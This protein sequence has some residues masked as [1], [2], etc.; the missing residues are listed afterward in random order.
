MRLD[1]SLFG[2]LTCLLGL[3][4]A[5]YPTRPPAQ[6]E[7]TDDDDTATVTT[8]SASSNSIVSLASAL[9][10][11]AVFPEDS[12]NRTLQFVK[13]DGISELTVTAVNLV[14]FRGDEVI[15]RAEFTTATTP[16][17]NASLDKRDDDLDDRSLL[18]PLPLATGNDSVILAFTTQKDI[19]E[20]HINEALYLEFQWENSTSSGSSFSPVLAIYSTYDGD[21]GALQALQETGKMDGEPAK[22][23]S[24]TGSADDS[25]PTTAPSTGA[26]TSTPTSEASGNQQGVEDSSSSSSSSG[27]G[28]L[29][30]G[31]IAGIAVGCTLAGLALLGGVLPWFFCFRRR[32]RGRNHRNKAGFA[33]DSGS[34]A[35]MFGKEITSESTTHSTY[36]G[37]DD[38]ASGRGIT[39]DGHV[40]STPG[41]RPSLALDLDHD[42]YATPY[43]DRVP[44]P[45]AAVAL[46][47]TAVAATHRE[48]TADP[49]MMNRHDS[50]VG[51]GVGIGVGI[52]SGTGSVTSPQSPTPPGNSRLDSRLNSRYAHLVEEGMTEDEIRQL[53]AE[54]RHLDAAIEDAGRYSSRGTR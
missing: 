49:S 8:A 11:P 12:G 14:K 40:A 6:G 21:A 2:L 38:G 48:S 54:E 13:G 4:V 46:P 33:T 18:P 51:S 50:G 1:V 41:G 42:A 39:L 47:G 53:E 17:T 37:A 28:G 16:S 36:G 27:G 25:N 19:Y 24:I 15:A 31:A 10:T 30:D 9:P 32:R 35:M 3:A 5:D 29:S 20:K 44:T 43:S 22:P 7:E 34:R 23:E 52:G 26:A 45:P